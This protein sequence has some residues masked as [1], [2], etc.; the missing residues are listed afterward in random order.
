MGKGICT[1]AK[2][3][4]RGGFRNSCATVPRPAAAPAVRKSASTSSKRRRAAGRFRKSEIER[5]DDAVGRDLHVG[6][7]QVTMHDSAFVEIFQGCGDL[8]RDFPCVVE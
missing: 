8:R 3:T 6:R 5:L 2:S 7:L 1:L 4:A